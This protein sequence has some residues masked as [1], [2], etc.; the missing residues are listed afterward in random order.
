MRQSCN[1]SAEAGAALDPKRI[2]VGDHAPNGRNDEMS[3]CLFC[4][5]A[6]G[7][8]PS[9][10]VYEDD[11]LF[12]FKDISP[13]A[14]VHVLIIPKKHITGMAALVEGDESLVG[15][16]F[17]AAK[18]IAKDKSVFQCGYRMVANSGPDAGQAVD[19]LHF[20]LL[21]GRTLTWPPG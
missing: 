5:I 15:R 18:R 17:L 16:I 6:A 21:G 12:A 1:G 4:K 11:E 13:Q 9:D 14:P 7:D 10:V 8:I 2:A 3:D 19:H 20:H